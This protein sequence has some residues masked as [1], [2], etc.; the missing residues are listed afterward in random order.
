MT[1]KRMELA[2]ECLRRLA[3][4]IRSATLYSSSHPI[5]GRSV[6]ALAE[7]AKRYH[8]NQ[9]TITVGIVGSEVVVGDMPI[10]KAD[11]F[12]DMVRR[13]QAA[14]IERI[15]IE[16]GV[17]V[18]ELASL[19]HVLASPSHSSSSTASPPPFP[20]LPHIRVGRI[21]VEERTGGNL[22]DMATIRQLYTD[23]VSVANVVW[24]SAAREKKPDAAAAIA[25]IDGL[26]E[27]VLQNRTALMALTTLKN[28]DDYTFTH[29]VNVSIL[30]MAQARSLKIDG[31]LLREFGLAGLMHDIGKVKTPNE[32]LNKPDKLTDEEF[33]IMK[34]HT[35]DGAEILRRTPDVTALAPVVAFEHHLRLDGTGYPTGISRPTLNVCTMLCGIADVF[36]AM[37]SQRVYQQSHPTDRILAVLKRNDGAQFDQHLVRRFV[38]LIGI[39]PAGNLVRLD[40]GEVAVVV[41]AYAPDPHRPQVRVV[42]DKSG[43]RL[44]V[45]YDINLWEVSPERGGPTT[46]QSPVDPAEYDIDPLNHVALSAA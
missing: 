18:D 44:A 25:M 39:Y 7:A 37:R 31:P 27:A 26:A 15:T 29:M 19:V 17:G 42:F 46:V 35:V 34:R 9:P 24:E 6:T 11:T 45:P 28:Y 4:A 16:R 43:N 33:V 36:D 22:G 20:S 41:K 38:Q 12:G 40:T 30:T 21:Q 32:V 5:I 1:D 10:G 8:A 14:G 2:D 3:A 23:A 13:L